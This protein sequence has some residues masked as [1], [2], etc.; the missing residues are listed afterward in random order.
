MNSRKHTE[1]EEARIA[2][3]VIQAVL[4]GAS[5]KDLRGVSAEQM[6]SLYAFAYEF[7]EQG[8]LDD[9]EK[10]FHFLCIYDFYN[11]QYWMGLAAVHQLKQ[12]YQKAVDL[13]AVAFAQGKQDYRPMLYTGQC[14]LA[15]GKVG[16]A[17]LCFE[18]VVERV[19]ESGMRAQARA[20]LDAL[21]SVDADHSEE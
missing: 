19:Q 11:A 13:Y 21:S 18:Y 17:K 10:F 1:Q 14:Q 7:Y 16:K 3:E 12:N 4:D 5:L 15:L 2:E 8:R 9:A 6:D 20:Y